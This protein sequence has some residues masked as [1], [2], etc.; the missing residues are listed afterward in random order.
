M[1]QLYNGL[2][3]VYV[4]LYILVCRRTMTVEKFAGIKFRNFILQIC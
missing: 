1:H 4:I 2:S 3:T